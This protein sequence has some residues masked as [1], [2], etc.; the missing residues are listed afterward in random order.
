MSS[1]IFALKTHNDKI[2]EIR[3]TCLTHF[4]LPRKSACMARYIK[5]N[6]FLFHK[7]I[8]FER[9]CKVYFSTKSFSFNLFDLQFCILFIVTHG[10]KFFQ[11]SFGMCNF[12]IFINFWSERIFNVRIST[13][14]SYFDC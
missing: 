10:N 8:F 3:D 9:F 7:V 6:R 1:T 2:F 5:N 11:G 12:K 4:L 14:I 13:G